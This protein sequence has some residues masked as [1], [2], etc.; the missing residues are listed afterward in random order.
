MTLFLATFPTSPLTALSSLFLFG[1]KGERGANF[2]PAVLKA[3]L[4]VHQFVHEPLAAL[5]GHL[6][7]RPDFQ[8][9][10]AQLE[11]QLA[12]VFDR[13]GGTLDLTL[14]K[15]SAGSLI[16]VLNF[17]DPEVGGDKFDLRLVHLVK[18]RHEDQ[19]P[20]ADWS[21]LQP[22]AEARLIQACEDEKN[23]LS[24]HEN[25]HLL[26]KDILASNGPERH[27]EVEM[28][29]QDLLQS[30]EDLVRRGLGRIRQLLD[31]A[32]IPP[33]A[34]EFC[35]ATG[36]MVA[37]PAI[38]HGLLE[39]FGMARLRMIENAATV[40]S[41]GAAW[42]AHDGLT[43]RLAKPLELLHAD[44]VHVPIIHSRTV[45]PEEGKQ[46]SN[47]ISMFCV[48]PRDGFA[49]FEFA[50]PRWPERESQIDARLPY[51]HLTIRVDPHAQPLNERLEVRVRIDQD[52]IAT[53]SAESKLTRD[54]RVR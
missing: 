29:R 48:D 45:L 4:H 10:I 33:S 2:S 47:N 27:L 6:R 25:A 43:L 46:I 23:R 30:V 36:G 42:I 50:R 5:Y 3:N 26:V 19:H 39:I 37:V 7:G 8:Q 38:R 17:G 13:G 34:V 35:L 40:I 12:I 20:A 24:E 16:Q 18:Q 53:V 11:G 52:L 1:C 31:A 44:N 51:T 9:Q 32:E 21:R 28:T 22:T 15:F 41:E 49:K 14:C 54:S